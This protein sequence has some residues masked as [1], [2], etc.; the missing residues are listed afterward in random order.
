MV[1]KISQLRHEKAALDVEN[2]SLTTKIEILTD[3]QRAQSSRNS[4]SANDVMQL[5]E[6]K[7]HLE[8]TLEERNKA[9]REKTNK[10]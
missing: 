8:L 1:F 2:Q 3:D 6:Q 9:I 4:E 5:K 7:A 10:L